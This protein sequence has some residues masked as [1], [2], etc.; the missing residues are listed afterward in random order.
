MPEDLQ[1]CPA[2]ALQSAGE[3][4]PPSFAEFLRKKGAEFHV[5]DRHVRR[6]EWLGALN[7]LF[8]QIRGWLRES[9][10]DGL[11]DFVPYEVSRTE[12][13]LGTYDA[14]ALKIQLGPAEAH[15]KPMGREV[16]S[17]TFRGTSGAAGDFAGRV[18]LTDGLREYWLYREKH[19]EGDRW[20]IHDERGRF[21]DLNR[22][23]FERILQE[24]L[25]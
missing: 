16:P 1:E 18:A 11:L 4:P 5:R 12:P 13:V 8:D 22:T 3:A 20:Q 2:S 23:E 24:L 6:T 7:Q 10:P 25:S 15:L 17:Y 19:P 9:D 21:T 14:P